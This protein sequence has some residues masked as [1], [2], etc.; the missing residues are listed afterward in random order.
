MN[1]EKQ[2]VENIY[3]KQTYIIV[4][5][6]NGTFRSFPEDESNPEYIKFLDSLAIEEAAKNAEATVE[7][8]EIADTTPAET[9]TKSPSTKS[10][11]KK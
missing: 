2:V 9:K 10:K 7:P 11:N 4:D 5:N 8:A 3:G 6:E 1:Y